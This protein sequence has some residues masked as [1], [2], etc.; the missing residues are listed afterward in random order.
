[1]MSYSIIDNLINTEPHILTDLNIE[2]DPEELIERIRTG[3]KK[4]DTLLATARDTLKK[5]NNIW[6]PGI[7][8]RW[9]P[10]T[11]S[12]TE[13]GKS[14]VQSSPPVI[15]DLGHSANFVKAAS[16]VLVA[17][18]SAGNEIEEATRKTSGNQ[19]PLIS[20]L[21]DLI[22][23]LVLEKTGKIINTLA[24]Q[25]ASELGWG[26]SPFLS[27]GSVHGWKLEEQVKI[28]SLLPLSK[29]NISIGDDAVLSPFKSLSC[30]IGI[31]TGYT[32]TRVG[33]TCQ[34]CSKNNDCE[35]K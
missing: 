30:M 9:F 1:M 23:L 35:M 33:T 11:Q 19:T 18:Y 22:G 31:G 24:E 17:A 21:H 8:Y 29:I 3:T 5:I 16:H 7:T 27:P 6:N 4:S 26:V 20:F 13:P 2:V 28:C 34:V 25:K 32:S 12:E 15:L 14:T 10:F